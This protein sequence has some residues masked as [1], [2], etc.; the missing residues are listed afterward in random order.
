MALPQ[1]SS[2]SSPLDHPISPPSSPELKPPPRN[3]RRLQQLRYH[4]AVAPARSSSRYSLDDS[5]DPDDASPTTIRHGSGALAMAP[6]LAIQPVSPPSSPEIASWRVAPQPEIVSPVDDESDASL[7]KIVQV[8]KGNPRDLTPP[9]ETPHYRHI[10][11]TQCGLPSVSRHGPV[12]ASGIDQAPAYHQ[13]LSHRK[14]VKDENASWRPQLP[15]QRQAPSAP[16]QRPPQQT[17]IPERD[18][19]FGMRSKQA[20]RQAMPLDTRPPWHG[21]SG[22]ERQVSALQDDL[23]VPP[24]SLSNNIGK[25]N[26]PKGG[27]RSRLSHMGSPGMDGTSGPGATMRKFI[28]AKTHRKAGSI[29]TQSPRA[30][31]DMDASEPRPDVYPSPPHQDRYDNAAARA[32][33]QYSPGQSIT[34]KRKPPPGAHIRNTDHAH[35]L[36]SSPINDNDIPNPL[37]PESPTPI[38]QAGGDSWIQPPSRFSTTTYATTTVGMTSVESSPATGVESNLL[39]SPFGGPLPTNER[40]RSVLDAPSAKRSALVSRPE[41]SASAKSTNKP[42]D[43]R[44]DG[45]IVTPRRASFS[46]ISKPLPPAPPEVSASD[47][48]AHLTAQLDSLSNRRMNIN[49]CVKQMTELIPTDNLLDSYEVQRKRGMERKKIDALKTELAE[50]QREEHELGLMLHRAYKR[51]NKEAVYEPTTLWVRRVAG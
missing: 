2:Y 11:D 49:K 22:R 8:I 33:P 50:V 27:F 29:S 39:G 15:P 37:T 19:S 38:Q 46:S 20:G 21:A 5:S 44:A 32:S 17:I 16:M 45:A 35:P 18:S 26:T 10:P 25:R 34:I 40:L 3:P 12:R 23:S 30:Q 41:T 47:R 48:I 28:S 6:S 42:S 36:A 43:S 51:Q 4:T 9:A 13:E 7:E 14:P 24:L 31:Y 1:N